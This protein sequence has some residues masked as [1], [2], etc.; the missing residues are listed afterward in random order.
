MVH[1]A[2]KIPPFLM[3]CDTDCEKRR[4]ILSKWM[5]GEQFEEVIDGVLMGVPHNFMK[6][7]Y[8]CTFLYR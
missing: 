1:T 2:K 5:N 3:L 4:L 7:V 6:K 8:L